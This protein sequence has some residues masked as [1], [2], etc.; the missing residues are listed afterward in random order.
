PPP[1]KSPSPQSRE[2]PLSIAWSSRP[3]IEQTESELVSS[4][5]EQ[6][7]LGSG[8]HTLL[9]VYTPNRNFMVHN[10][11]QKENSSTAMFPDEDKVTEHRAA[12]ETRGTKLPMMLCYTRK[13]PPR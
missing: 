5:T 11:K 9:K 4:H 2:S 6:E 10:F 7:V 13:T 1:L 3:I 8:V 12:A